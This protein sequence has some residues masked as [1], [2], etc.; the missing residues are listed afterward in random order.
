MASA[1]GTFTPIVTNIKLAPEF[2]PYTDD[3]CSFIKDFPYDKIL[4]RVRHLITR[5][6]LDCSFVRHFYPVFLACL[7]LFT[8]RQP[9]APCIIHYMQSYAPTCHCRGNAF[10][11]PGY[12]DAERAAQDPLLNFNVGYIYTVAAN[13][14]TWSTKRQVSVATSSTE[15]E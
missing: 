15:A 8:G 7:M 14:I 3:D 5:T 12:A 10:S 2:Y 9:S 6:R 13:A 11:F 1:A 4:S